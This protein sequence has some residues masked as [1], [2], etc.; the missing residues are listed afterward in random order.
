MTS[1]LLPPQSESK[2]K[3]RTMLSTAQLLFVWFFPGVITWT[4]QYVNRW[5]SPF[6]AGRNL[7]FQAAVGDVIAVALFLWRWPRV[8][9]VSR[10]R[11]CFMDLA[12]GTGIGYLMTNI[13]ALMIGRTEFERDWLLTN[14]QRR[15]TFFC[16]VLIAPAAEE[17]I[18]RGAILC[19]LLAKMPMPWAVLI[20]VV[21][22]AVQHDVWWLALPGQILLCVAY[23]IRGR[24]LASSTIAHLVANAVVFWPT[25][26]FAFHLNRL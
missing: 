24:S 25:I 5:R 4:I 1:D 20:T 3:D 8:F 2:Q 12:V 23:L 22:A 17:L 19:S 7:P 13:Q 26:L 10:I 18:Y 14:S 9:A 11:P 15:L 16:A 21:A 6:T